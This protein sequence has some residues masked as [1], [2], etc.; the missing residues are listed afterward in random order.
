MTRD[1]V[2]AVLGYFEWS[3]EHTYRDLTACLVDTAFRF[4]E[5]LSLQSSNIDLNGNKIHL[6]DSKNGKPRFV[7]MTKR[8]REIMSIRKALGLFSSVKYLSYMDSWKRMIKHVGF[9]EDVVLHTPRHTTA[10]H[11]VQAGIHLQVVKEVLGH[12]SIQTTLRYA[13][14]APSNIETGIEA[15]EA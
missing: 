2:K 11:L 9:D 15:L 5:M 4:D 12:T 10:S 14:L 1:E 8:V 13:H 3:G 6:Y 7:P